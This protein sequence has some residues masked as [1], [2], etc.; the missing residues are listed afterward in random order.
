[1]PTVLHVHNVQRPGGT[2]NFAF[3]FARCFAGWRHLAVCVNDARGDAQWREDVAP[4]L[5]T[6]YAPQ[7]T[8]A[9]LDELSPRVVVLHATAARSL[10]GSYP[11]AWLR[12]SGRLVISWHHV[13]LSPIIPADLDVYES[14]FVRGQYS[15]YVDQIARGVVCPPCTDLAPYAAIPRT[16]P[17]GRRVTTA[18]KSCAEA[19]Q[20][21][22]ETPDWSWCHRPPGRVGSMPAYLA[23]FDVAVVWSGLQETWCRTVTEAMA[24]GCLTLAHRAGAIPEQIEHGRNGFLFDTREEAAA[25]LAALPDRSDLEAIREAGRVS[26]LACGGFDRLRSTLGPV[27]E[28]ASR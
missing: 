8:P 16:C 25:L 20:L 3:D 12:A 9:I 22:R 10:A 24:A 15:P 2:G 1:M 14:E 21:A 5:R 7:L 4:Q 17:S 19:E 18:G 27:L 26:A 11:W 13:A 6:F 23:G 28:E